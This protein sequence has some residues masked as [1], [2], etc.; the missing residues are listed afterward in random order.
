MGF[1]GIVGQHRATGSLSRALESGRF[2][3]SLI[4]HGP[5]GVGKLTTALSLCRILLCSDGSGQ[6][7]GRCRACRRIEDRSLRHP[8]IRV[9]FPEKL[10]DFQ[11]GGTWKEGS[12]GLDLQEMQSEAIRNPVWSILI[13]RVRQ[14][15]TFLQRRPSEGF[16]SVLL[17]DQA[18]RMGPEAANALLKTLEEPPD[19]AVLILLTSSLHALLPTIRSRC[20]D[21]AF[22]LVSP[23]EIAAYVAARQNCGPEEARLRAALSG[24]RI[25]T[26]L[27]IDL[28]EFRSR[29]DLLLRVIESLFKGGDPGLAIARA[30][31]IARKGDSLESELHV[32]MTLLRDLMILGASGASDSAIVN[33]DLLAPLTYLAPAVAESA[34]F[35]LADLEATIDGIRRKGNRQ[36]LV[37]DFLL[38]MLPAPAFVSRSA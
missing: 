10:S 12:S 13:D 32:L 9:V 21:I 29:R 27:D 34:P 28:E 8:D 22:Q 37:E 38:R 18:H 3:P 23:S 17:I 2:T 15:R 25:G 14:G 36:L 24:G 7:C 30:E 1:S 11:K 4:F 35:L 5:T 33:S 6:A 31:E 20:Q 19:H 26:A 16:R